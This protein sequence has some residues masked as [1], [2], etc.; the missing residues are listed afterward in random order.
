MVKYVMPIKLRN[1]KKVENEKNT[2]NHSGTG[3]RPEVSGRKGE[4]ISVLLQDKR[5]NNRLRC[6]GCGDH[7]GK[8]P[9]RAGP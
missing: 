5:G 2:C 4:G 3:E 6:G 8:Y 9:C 7:S 1:Y